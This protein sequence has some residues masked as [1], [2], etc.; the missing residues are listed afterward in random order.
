ME[1]K[2]SDTFYKNNL[3]KFLKRNLN[4]YVC[5]V[6]LGNFLFKRF[7]QQFELEN[8]EQI[9]EFYYQ[10][11]W[12][13]MLELTEKTGPHQKQFEKYNLEFS[14]VPWVEVSV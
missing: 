13:K 5:S 2:L 6:D 4:N 9:T 7:N 11:P 3:R 1:I 12:E 14:T 10:V 8:E